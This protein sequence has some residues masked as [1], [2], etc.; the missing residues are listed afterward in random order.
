MVNTRSTSRDNAEG[1]RNEDTVIQEEVQTEVV[2][3]E[4]MGTQTCVTYTASTDQEDREIMI[5]PSPAVHQSERNTSRGLQRRLSE[6]GELRGGLYIPRGC[7]T[8]DEFKNLSQEQFD[9][10]MK[11]A[12]N[13]LMKE[14]RNSEGVC[15]DQKRDSSSRKGGD[16]DESV[17]TISSQQLSGNPSIR[18]TIAPQPTEILTRPNYKHRVRE[19]KSIDPYDVRRFLMDLE[20][21]GDYHGIGAHITGQVFKKICETF[22][23]SLES[24]DDNRILSALKSLAAVNVQVDQL[25]AYHIMKDFVYKHND[26]HTRDFEKLL[27]KVMLFHN[28]VEM[29]DSISKKK[30]MEKDALK[31]LADILPSGLGYDSITFR[32]KGMTLKDLVM[33]M[34][35]L[36]KR[37][38]GRQ[39]TDKGKSEDDSRSEISSEDKSEKE[40]ESNLTRE[41]R[42]LREALTGG[43]TRIAATTVTPLSEAERHGI[44]LLCA[45]M[46]ICTKCYE[47][48]VEGHT[49]YAIRQESERVCF[50]C[51]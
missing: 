15:Q 19:L 20:K 47:H 22:Q 18:P 25:G 28:E 10:L 21:S 35:E 41:F 26:F 37:R 34:K 30:R 2:S 33:D 43:S 8:P 6:M 3:R 42:K 29:E 45:E 24:Q 5:S 51:K 50:N 49:C 27:Q 9:L 7:T 36:Y 44:N 48:D 11:M 17:V 39:T 23:I 1:K 46:E 38:A 31:I 4:M 40:N 16:D 13:E 12:K 14:S 32:A